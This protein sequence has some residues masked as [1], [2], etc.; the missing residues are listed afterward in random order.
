MEKA[1]GSRGH[2]AVLHRGFLAER[3][4]PQ[5]RLAAFQRVTVLRLHGGRDTLV[6]RTPLAARSSSRMMRRSVFSRDSWVCW[7]GWRRASLNRVW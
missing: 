7:M 1:P 6:Q 4:G 2:P 3:D 5:N